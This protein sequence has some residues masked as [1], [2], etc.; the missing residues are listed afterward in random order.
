MCAVVLG[1]SCVDSEVGSWGEWIAS[2]TWVTCVVEVFGVV[3][4]VTI[5]YAAL[6]GIRVA[7]QDGKAITYISVL[8]ETQRA[9]NSDVAMF[10]L[11]FI[12]PSPLAVSLRPLGLAQH[13]S[14]RI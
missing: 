8:C 14:S 9:S 4:A 2:L 5:S 1:K 10:I 7:E 3:S 13:C 11:I 6:D 12:L